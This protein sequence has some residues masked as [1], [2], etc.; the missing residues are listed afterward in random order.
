[1]V[2][3]IIRLCCPGVGI[4]HSRPAEGD[5]CMFS[6]IKIWYMYIYNYK[7]EQDT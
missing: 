1:M 4:F 5:I 6:D 7:Q 3:G 2:G